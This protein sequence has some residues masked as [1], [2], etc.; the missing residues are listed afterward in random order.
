MLPFKENVKMLIMSLEAK[1]YR[2]RSRKCSQTHLRFL[3]KRLTG[4]VKVNGEMLF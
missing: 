1:M 3:N 2:L 4:I